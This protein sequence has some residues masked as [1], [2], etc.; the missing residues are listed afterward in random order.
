[1]PGGPGQVAE[2]GF[3]WRSILG[4]SRYCPESIGQGVSDG[5]QSKEFPG[6]ASGVLKN[7]I[8]IGS[9]SADL[10]VCH[11]P[12]DQRRVSQHQRIRARHSGKL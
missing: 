1:M 9:P 8:R 3:R 12:S 10:G 11:R 4:S 7:G 2:G 5:V 6:V